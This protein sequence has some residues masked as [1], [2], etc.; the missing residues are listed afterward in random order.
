MDEHQSIDE[1]SYV[2][3]DRGRKGPGSVKRVQRVVSTLLV[4]AVLIALVVAGTDMVSATS[5]AYLI[6]VDGQEVAALVSE[7]EADEALA[8]AVSNEQQ[9]VG[10][11]GDFVLTYGNDVE[12]QEVPSVGVEYAS[13]SEVAD[14]LISLLDFQAEGVALLVDDQPVFY[15][16]SAETAIQAVNA[17]KSHYGSTDEE[18]VS[19]VYTEQKISIVGSSVPLTDVLTGPQAENMLLYG[20]LTAAEGE[21]TPLVDVIVE[22]TFSQEEP[23]PFNTVREDDDTLLRGKEKVVTEGKDGVQEVFYTKQ[24]RNGVLVST[25]KTG[26]EVLE[27]AVDE[28]IHV[29]TKLLISSAYSGAFSTAGSGEFGWPLM[30][31]VGIITSVF[32][33]REWGWHSGIDIANAIYTTIV[34][35]GDGTVTRTD[36]LGGYGLLVCIDHGNGVE[37]R[38]A[39]CDEVFVGVG[40]TV[41]RGQPIATIGMTGTTTGPHVHFEVRVD[42]TAVDPLP[43]L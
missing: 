40:D 10:G 18:D 22:R 31:G 19:S 30:D 14:Q 32:G 9:R 11:D 38:Y 5:N 24:E 34:A 28:V 25:V 4:L 8:L 27:P 7:R 3:G 20:S 26:S 41:K 36:Y 33:W 15:V 1:A 6:C 2:K 16:S 17:V 39:H 42:D 21:G 29:G 37:T 12:I 43:Y 13:V 23:L 35:S